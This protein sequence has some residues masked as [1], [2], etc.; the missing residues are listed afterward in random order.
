LTLP[1]RATRIPVA[2]KIISETIKKFEK[3]DFDQLVVFLGRGYI[4]ESKIVDGVTYYQGFVVS[5]PGIIGGLQTDNSIKVATSPEPGEKIDIVEVS[6]YVD[7]VSL[8]P[9][10][11]LKMGP[12]FRITIERNGNGKDQS[13]AYAMTSPLEDFDTAR[14]DL[15]YIIFTLIGTSIVVIVNH[16]IKF[17]QD[18]LIQ[19]IIRFTLTVILCFYLYRGSNPARVIT[20]ILTSITALYCFAKG[21]EILRVFST[22]WIGIGLGAIYGHIAAVLYSSPSVR[23]YFK[24]ADSFE[25]EDSNSKGQ[26]HS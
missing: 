22:G 7:C 20:L 19:Q 17:G 4:K 10:L 12:S 14:R 3:M 5:K 21:I 11:Y 23:G 8:L 16:N 9:F 2:N 26:K 15:F 25:V 1:Q 6:G 18:R 24:Q 13:S